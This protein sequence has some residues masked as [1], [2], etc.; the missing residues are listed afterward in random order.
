M[1]RLDYAIYGVHTAFW[2][3]FVVTRLILRAREKSHQ[4]AVGTGPTATQELTGRFSRTVLAIHALAFFI[5]YLGI[6]YAVV[7]GQVPV[8]F[9]WQRAVGTVVIAVGA[10]LMAWALVHFQSWRLRAKLDSGHQLATGGP[11]RFLRHPI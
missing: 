6:G 10:V 4:R 8:W 11:F 2:W 3:T 5:M 9:P 7:S 1:N